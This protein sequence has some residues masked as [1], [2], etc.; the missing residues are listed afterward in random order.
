M[1]KRILK[2]RL[3]KLEELKEIRDFLNHD[4]DNYV[5]NIKRERYSSF[6]NELQVFNKKLKVDKEIMLE[7]VNDLITYYENDIDKFLEGSDE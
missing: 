4:N 1:D 2:S 5:I 6:F 7:I 3:D